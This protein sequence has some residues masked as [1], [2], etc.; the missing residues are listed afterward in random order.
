MASAQ[1]YCDKCKQYGHTQNRCPRR[2]RQQH[3]QHQQHQQQF[4]PVMGMHPS[5][6]MAMH[7]GMG[8]HQGMHPGMAMAMHQGM[9]PG[10]HPGMMGM[11]HQEQ[12][13][14]AQ[15]FPVE[16]YHAVP[17]ELDENFW[18]GM[19]IQ[20]ISKLIGE[21]YQEYHS[22]M[23]GNMMQGGLVDKLPLTTELCKKQNLE[24][25]Q[26][27]YDMGLCFIAVGIASR[28]LQRKCKVMLKGKTG[29]YL[30]ADML[31]VAGDLENQTTDDIDLVILAKHDSGD[32]VTRKVFAQ[33]VGAFITACLEYKREMSLQSAFSQAVAEG[34]QRLTYS[35][36]DVVLRG[37]GVCGKQLESKNV[38]VSLGDTAAPRKKVKLVDIT[39]TTYD[40]MIDKLYSRVRRCTIGRALTFFYLHV[41][42]ALMEYVYIIYNNVRQCRKFI[43]HGKN[44]SVS[45]AAVERLQLQQHQEDDPRPHCD[46]AACFLSNLT[47]FEQKTMFKFSRSAFLCA[48]VIA[49]LPEYETAGLPADRLQHIQKRIVLMQLRKLS[50]YG[51]ISKKFS[52]TLSQS[53]DVLSEM[54]DDVILQQRSR[55]EFGGVEM[56]KHLAR[57]LLASELPAKERMTMRFLRPVERF[58]SRSVPAFELGQM[59]PEE[60]VSP[61]SPGTSDS[62]T[63]RG[64]LS[65]SENERTKR[66]RK[67]HKGYKHLTIKQKRA[68]Q[69]FLKNRREITGPH[70]QAEGVAAEAEDVSPL[71][72]DM[73]SSDSGVLGFRTPMSNISPRSEKSSDGNDDDEKQHEGGSKTR[74]KRNKKNTRN[75]NNR[76]TKRSTKKTTKRSTKK[77]NM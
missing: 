69:K 40:P 54:L 5:M 2:N 14:E 52:S 24:N 41:D 13:D 35:C 1:E 12:Q 26:S 51:V 50:R 63:S 30:C 49:D 20:D 77:K 62:L 53:Y 34:N 61:R 31:K 17:V 44:G 15:D 38:K 72:K 10:M 68:R 8:M 45:G 43:G 36:V 57:R 39:Y 55:D 59:I 18:Q 6:A 47:D 58:D 74:Y 56:H 9:H 28:T 19:G 25:P 4:Y 16:S 73:T 65:G 29:L 3:Q 67:K 11:Y 32:D 64:H 46:S 70:E 60:L 66:W 33:Q 7:P 42:V 27:N 75:R 22:F 76:K 48:S 23:F 21:V 37:P 71:F